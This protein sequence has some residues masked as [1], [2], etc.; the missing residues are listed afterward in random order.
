MDLDSIIFYDDEWILY[1]DGTYQFNWLNENHNSGENKMQ[2]LG[3][4]WNKFGIIEYFVRPSTNLTSALFNNSFKN[5]NLKLRCS[6][7]VDKQYNLIVD[8]TNPEF[9]VD[10]YKYIREKNFTILSL[11]PE[12]EKDSP[13][14]SYL[15]KNFN[16][17]IQNKNKKYNGDVIRAMEDFLKKEP[18]FFEEGV[19]TFTEN[20]MRYCNKSRRSVEVPLISPKCY[21]EN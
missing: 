18:T 9:T 21:M 17:Y 4:W 16:Q 14:R 20:C 5:V 8:F 11:P 2:Q 1:N 19:L 6:K 7:D 13:T 15:F 10:T 3:V 12:S